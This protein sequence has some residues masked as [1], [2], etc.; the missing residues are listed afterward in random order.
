MVTCVLFSSTPLDQPAVRVHRVLSGRPAALCAQPL[1]EVVIVLVLWGGHRSGGRYVASRLPSPSH[2]GG[3]F[4]KLPPEGTKTKGS[5]QE[6]LFC[7]SQLGVA[8]GFR[9]CDAPQHVSLPHST[10][11]CSWLILRSFRSSR[12]KS[13]SF[14]FLKSAKQILFT[15][16]K[17]RLENHMSWPA[18]APPSLAQ[19]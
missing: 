15:S 4:G 12:S 1:P 5:V 13:S 11:G 9:K 10:K 6:Q 8:L 19:S 17:V 7:F 16:K 14:F 3:G 2:E 18:E